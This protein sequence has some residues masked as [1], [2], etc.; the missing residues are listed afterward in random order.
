VVGADDGGVVVVVVA[1]HPAALALLIP[2]AV[3]TVL[4]VGVDIVLPGRGLHLADEDAED[5]DAGGDDGYAGL[6][7]APD[8]EVDAVVWWT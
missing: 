5:G 6:G 3:G 2:R 4:A 8:I 1:S 7:V